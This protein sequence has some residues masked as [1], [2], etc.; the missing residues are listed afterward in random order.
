MMTIDFE[1]N[2][3][4]NQHL[5][6]EDPGNCCIRCEDL[7]WNNHYL[8]IK[9]IRGMSYCLEYGPI[10]VEAD[11]LAENFTVKFSMLKFNEKKLFGKISNFLN[12]PKKQI[13][14][15][16]LDVDENAFDDF[17]DVIDLYKGFN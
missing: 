17:P 15:A 11:T 12:D 16:I 9:T 3:T 8:V 2:K 13:T 14:S 1:V 7:D 4:F 5:D 6:I 10:A